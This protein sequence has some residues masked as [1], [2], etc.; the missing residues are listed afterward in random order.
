MKK[1]LSLILAVMVL[2]SF[3][4]CTGGN[5][6]TSTTESTKETEGSSPINA[7]ENLLSVTVTLAANLFEG[8][9][10]E[11]IKAAAK[12]DGISKCVVNEDGSV[13]YT[14][15]KSK[16]KKML[17]DFEESIKNTTEDFVN[18]ENKVASFVEIKTN[19]DFSE[20]NIYVDSA[21]YS[22]WDSMNAMAFY[23]QGLYYQ[24]LLGK[25]FNEVDVVVNFIDNATQ[26]II[27]TSS[28]K[29]I[30]EN[31]AESEN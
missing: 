20:F 4:A 29:K 2:V 14:M 30:A 22:V 26:K 3:T 23:L 13:T 27:D 6:E 7:E 5:D 19:E 9:T 1:I 10:E 8:E 18:G 25:D 24:C 15:S 11:E 16:H 28:Y 31:M 12:E 21:K 17:E